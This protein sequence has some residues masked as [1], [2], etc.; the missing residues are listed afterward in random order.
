MITASRAFLLAAASSPE[1][2]AEA[3]C[4][5]GRAVQQALP[6]ADRF[7]PASAAAVP[8]NV[9]TLSGSRPADASE[10]TAE[11][12]LETLEECCDSSNPE[13]VRKAAVQALAA[14]RLLAANLVG[15][16]AL[17]DDVRCAQWQAAA[18]RCMLKLMEDEDNVVR[19]VRLALV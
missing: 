11:H 5:Y 15:P 9:T 17:P 4:C 14:S 19:Q 18:W 6:I 2:R 10:A 1:S 8:T 12:F 13:D 16:G 3:L 7:S